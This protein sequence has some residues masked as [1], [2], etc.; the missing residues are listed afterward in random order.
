MSSRNRNGLLENRPKKQ[1][2]VRADNAVEF[3]IPSERLFSTLVLVW[4]SARTRRTAA[5][6]SAL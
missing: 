1:K 2:S 6:N 4:I 3:R 5:V